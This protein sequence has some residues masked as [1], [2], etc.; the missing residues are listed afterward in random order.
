MFIRSNFDCICV[1]VYL[2]LTDIRVDCS[3]SML[4]SALQGRIWL[5]DKRKLYVALAYFCDMHLT[6]VANTMLRRLLY[7]GISN[8]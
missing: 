8:I 2:Q 1:F 5:E 4:L 3:G 7:A 6:I